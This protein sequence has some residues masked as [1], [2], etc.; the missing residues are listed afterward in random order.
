M[1]R[2]LSRFLLVLILVAGAIPAFARG[3]NEAIPAPDAA[4]GDQSPVPPTDAATGTNAAGEPGLL[5]PQTA[6][7]LFSLGVM[8][9]QSRIPSEN[10]V[11]STPDG[12][13]VA[14]EDYR[15]KV[16]FLN[17]W[18][19]WCPPCR[20]EMPSMQAL[21]E[22][23]AE[24][25]LAI[26]AVNVLEPEELVSDFIDENGFTFPVLLDH[27][28]RVQLRYSVRAYPTTYIIDRGGN[29]IAVRPGYHDWASPEIVDAFRALLAQ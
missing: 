8:P 18:A 7:I 3:A 14:L 2:V 16:V 5:D 12:D 28:G 6:E 24:E 21:Y 10:F 15:G 13:D 19:T 1:L 23:L 22:E 11:L 20:E 26:V 4:A 29:V 25:G 27:D 9:F 17:F